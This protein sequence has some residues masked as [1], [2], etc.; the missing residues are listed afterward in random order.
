[1]H[2]MPLRALR[3]GVHPELRGHKSLDVIV[4]VA[5]VLQVA[6]S[7]RT[8][9]LATARRRALQPALTIAPVNWPPEG[10][11]ASLV[12]SPARSGKIPTIRQ[13]RAPVPD[14]VPRQPMP[15]GR[16]GF[17]RTSLGAKR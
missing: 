7:V 6:R 3:L 5:Q 1:M 9:D 8:R 4:N 17:G 14:P 10:Q 16:D 13:Q 11:I 2:R 12:R 15:V